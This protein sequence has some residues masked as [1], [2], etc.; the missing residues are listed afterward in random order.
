MNAFLSTFL[1]LWWESSYKADFF[2]LQQL[3]YSYYQSSKL[4]PGYLW[5]VPNSHSRLDL[6]RI[7]IQQLWFRMLPIW[8]YVPPKCVHI[9]G[10]SQETNIKLGDDFCDI[11]VMKL[12]HFNINT[13]NSSWMCKGSIWLYSWYHITYMRHSSICLTPPPC[14]ALFI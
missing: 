7:F 1:P 10:I 11:S 3:L 5:T 4:I 9:G 2:I 12:I 14:A 6:F 8:G 13:V